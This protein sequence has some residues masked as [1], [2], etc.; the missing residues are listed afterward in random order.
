MSDTPRTDAL[1][2]AHENAVPPRASFYDFVE[3]CRTLER[4]LAEAQRPFS[5]NREEMLERDLAEERQEHQATLKLAREQRE[6][7]E[8]LGEYAIQLKE[9]CEQAAD[10]FSGIGLKDAAATLRRKIDALAKNPDNPRSFQR[11]REQMS[12]EAQERAAARTAEILSAENANWHP[13]GDGSTVRDTPRAH[14]LGVAPEGDSLAVNCRCEQPYIV[15]FSN[16][17]TGEHGRMC[18]KCGALMSPVTG[19]APKPSTFDE[20]GPFCSSS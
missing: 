8:A 12:P 7:H 1:V 9:L 18:T 19:D 11:L 4:E 10:T 15:P 3:L 13:G 17:D 20:H 5:N 14:R 16:V 2:M 6:A